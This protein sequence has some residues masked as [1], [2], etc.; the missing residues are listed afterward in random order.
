A[1]ERTLAG[2][3]SV[4]QV[5]FSDDAFTNLTVNRKAQ[6][7]REESRNQLRLDIAQA[8]AQAY[9]D[10]LRGKTLERIQR[11]NL[12]RTEANLELARARESVGYSGPGEVYR[13][14]G[15][16]AT[17]RRK[18]IEANARR[19]VA[20]IQVNRLRSRPSEESFR[21]E[22]TGLEATPLALRDER[23]RRYLGDPWSFRILR[24]FLSGVALEKSPEIRALD[25]SIA[26]Q[27]RVLTNTGRAFVLPTVAL[28]GELNHTFDRSGAGTDPATSLADPKDTNW[29]V[30]IEATL[31]LFAGGSRAAERRR[32]HDSLDELR[33]IRSAVAER[34]EQRLRSA[35]HVAGASYAGIDLSAQAAD[36]ARRNYE[37]VADAY[38]KGVVSVLDLIDA[39]NAYDVAEQGAAS[40]IY[41]FLIDYVEVERASGFLNCLEEDDPEEFI[42]R[43]DAFREE[44][45]SR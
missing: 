31:P 37:L 12:D 20:E 18:L 33:T 9:L 19:N 3:A 4:R 8:A 25:A 27:E 29:N 28:R 22:E 39:Q 26:A 43:L 10:V 38:S 21:T 36:A 41:D 24:E 23:L 13:W 17:Q 45:E 42:D 40:A 35:M 15:E 6:L 16:L 44:R 11:E 30:G 1:A 5:L 14:E 2:T 32:A 7:S 34:I